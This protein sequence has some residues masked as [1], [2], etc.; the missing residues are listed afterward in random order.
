MAG[1]AVPAAEGGDKPLQV[2]VQG[3]DMEKAMKTLKRKLLQEGFFREL[4]RRNFYE[5]PSVKKKR[6]R[7]EAQRR[8]RKAL[9]LKKTDK[10]DKG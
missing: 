6:K 1:T 10:Y 8:R 9:R 7:L 2:T 5:K 3:N 4:K